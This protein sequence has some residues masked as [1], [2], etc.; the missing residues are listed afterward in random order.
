[1]W[2]KKKKELPLNMPQH[3]AVIMD[4]NGRWAKQ[5]N[6]PRL[7]GHRAGV[8]AL[9]QIVKNADAFGVKYLTVYAFSTENWNRPSDEVTGLMDLIVFFLK[10]DLNEL[11][12]QG[13]RIRTIGDLSALPQEPLEEIN[14]AIEITKTNEKLQLIIALNYGGRQELLDATRRIA[15]ACTDGALSVNEIT[16]HLFSS[17]LYTKDIPDP[18]L[19]IRTSGEMRIS[20]FLLWQ[21]SYSEY[22]FTDVLWPDFDHAQ[23]LKAIESYSSRDRRFGKVK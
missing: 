11:I 1:M 10:R 2:F 8:E 12:R 4:G 18:D 19:V 13:V 16:D 14:S 5:R 22:Y 23:L 17:Y 20:N 9:K 7:A 21:S 15:E 6:L 3:I